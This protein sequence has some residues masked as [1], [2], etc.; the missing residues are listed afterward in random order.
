MSDMKLLVHSLEKLLDQFINQHKLLWK[1]GWVTGS[2]QQT[3]QQNSKVAMEAAKAAIAG[4]ISVLEIVESTPGVFEVV[5]LNFSTPLL[6][7][8]LDLEFICLVRSVQVLQQ[9]VKEHP[10]MA[11]EVGTV[12]KIEDA[13]SAINVRAKFL[14]SPATVKDIMEMDYVQSG[15]ILYISGTMTPTEVRFDF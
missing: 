7:L 6:V 14:M 5:Y 4:G 13:K 9:L 10:T 11:L 8:F 12:L 15:E 1:T 2:M 3:P